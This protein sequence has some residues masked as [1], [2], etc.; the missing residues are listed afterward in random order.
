M[1]SFFAAVIF[2]LVS[3]G[4]LLLALSLRILF[5][6]FTMS[7]PPPPVELSSGGTNPRTILIYYTPR[8]T[9]KGL[10]YD[11]TNQRWRVATMDKM[12]D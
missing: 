5:C 12:T 3:L 8:G 7:A 11:E 2:V 1:A 4:V 9:M 10:G 6:T